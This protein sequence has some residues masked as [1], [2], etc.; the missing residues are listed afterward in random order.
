MMLSEWKTNPL[1]LSMSHAKY[2][3]S[4]AEKW[5]KCPAM[6]TLVRQADYKVGIPA[7]T[8]TLIHQM[9][10]MVLKERL[11]NATL[12]DYWFGTKHVVEDFEIEVDEDMIDCAEM[13]VDYINKRTE[14]LNGKLLIEEKVYLS[15]ISPDLWGTADAIILTKEK[16]AVIDLKSGK[17]PVDVDN[18][19]QLKIYA[20]GALARYGNEDTLVESTIVQP[21]ARHKNGKIRSTEYS[22]ENLVNWADEFLT[23]A[24][25]RCEEEEPEYVYGDHC[26]FCNARDICNTYKLNTGVKND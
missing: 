11:D 26:R 4:A 10:E 21:R 19:M 9:T 25:A 16:I 12:K 14:E 3:P 1:F 2:G 15:E 13:Y 18:N 8:G 17:Y 24:I 22:A 7:A 6:P 5:T 20:L 23:P